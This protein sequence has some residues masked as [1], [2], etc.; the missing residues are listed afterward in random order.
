MDSEWG[1]MNYLEKSPASHE[2]PD[3][4][5]HMPGTELRSPA[6]RHRSAGAHLTHL[7]DHESPPG[8]RR[9]PES[10]PSSPGRSSSASDHRADR[11][12]AALSRAG[13]VA[14]YAAGFLLAV[15]ALFALPLQAEAQ[16]TYV[17]N[18]GQSEDATSFAISAVDQQAQGF[19]TGTD[20]AGYTL[21]SV[22]IRLVSTF[23]SDISGSDITVTIVQGTPT[24]TVVATL[25][26]PASITANTTADYTFTAPAD[27]TLTASTT[28]YVVLEGDRESI[29]TARTNSDSEDSGGESN[30]SIA[31]VSNWRIANSTGSFGATLMI[32]IKGPGGTTTSSD[33]TLTDLTVNDGTTDLT[34]SPAFAS[35]TFVY[36]AS[37]TNAVDE[38]TLTA[39][40]THTGASVS[41]VTLGGTVIADTDFTDGITV[42]SL[43][44]GDN[45]IVV[46]VTA[47]DGSTQPY[48]VTVTRAGAGIPVTIEAEHESIGGGVEDLKFTLTR[49]GATTDPLT[50]TVT[51]TQDQNWLT[52]TYRTHDGPIRRRRGHQGADHRRQ[53]LLVRSHHQRQPGR[54][55]DRHGRRRRLG[56]RRDHL[57]R[58][59]AH[60][61]RLRQGRLQL[62]GGRPRERGRHL[63]DRHPG[64]GLPARTFVEFRCRHE[65]RRGHCHGSRR[66]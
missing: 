30:W 17:S 47:E 28:Y 26:P 64:R 56:H 37:V 19:T 36:T 54:H 34:L 5:Y 16:T 62:P 48:T 25:T 61:P 12:S 52:S 9:P 53:P 14:C 18:I 8:P 40:P 4:A 46:T 6:H 7:M 59:S 13:S 21:G 41:E 49:T 38:V 66:L 45:T 33:A 63:C 1:V 32:K 11:L 50:V 57:H 27:L 3:S 39:T 51:L 44:V 23:P 43:L 42:P 55:G 24:G 22:D 20:A 29:S 10:S 31:D 65:H 60:H 15:A 58:E 35:G 2:H